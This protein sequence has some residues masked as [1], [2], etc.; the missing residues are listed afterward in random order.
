[1]MESVLADLPQLSVLAITVRLLLTTVFAGTLGYERERHKQAAGFR[2][3]IIVADASALVMMTNIFIG[4]SVGTTDLVRMPASVIT[5]LGF[6]GAGTILVTKSQEIKGLTTAAG[7]WAVANIGLALGAG[8]YAGGAICYGFILVAM[9]ILRLVDQHIEKNRKVCEIYCEM[10]SAQV[11]GRMI[12]CARERD[13][14]VSDFSLYNEPTY[15]DESAPL[16]GTFMLWVGKKMT[17]EAVLAELDQIDGVQY[18]TT[19]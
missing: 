5:G 12:R 17:L 8:F 18:L 1:M 13:Y 9:N 3:Y 19:V 4:Q 10:R 15:G 2:T 6:L 7:L 16:C 11:I 14:S